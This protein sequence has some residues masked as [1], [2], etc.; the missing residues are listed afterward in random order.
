MAS[1]ATKLLK[2]IEPLAAPA[3]QHAVAVCALRLRGTAELTGLLAE[4]AAGGHYERLLAGRMA[5]VANESDFL[6]RQ[7]DSP[8]PELAAR[9]V[10][11]LVRARIEPDALLDRLPRMSHR[12]RRAL[13]RALGR[14]GRG[15]TADPLLPVIR[16]HFGDAE[17]ARILA[18]CTESTVAEYLPELDYAV[19][20]WAA[21]GHRHLDVVLAYAEEKADI[22]GESDWWELWPRVGA[23]ARAAAEHQPD[24]LLALARR[25]V[26]FTSV[27]QLRPVAGQLAR[28]DPA[29][30][31]ALVLHSSGRGAELTGQALWVA[32]RELPDER[33]IA[34]G[35]VYPHYHRTRFLRALAPARR[36]VVVRAVWARPGIDPGDID[37]TLLDLLPRPARAELARELLARPGGSEVRAVRERLTARL[38]WPDAEPVLAQAI[39]RP[40]ADER[41]TAYPL[42]IA[43]AFGARDPEVLGDLLDTLRRLRNE[44]DPVRAQAFQA[45]TAMPPTLL[46]PDHLPAL[47]QICADALEARDRSYSTTAAVATLA[48]LL[49]LRAATSTT[50]AAAATTSAATSTTSAATSMAGTTTTTGAAARTTGGFAATALRLLELLAAQTTRVPLGRIH[51]NLPRGAE[52]H[53]FEALRPRLD[54]DGARDEWELALDLAAGLDKRA[55]NL[56]DLHRMVL[57]A[58]GARSDSTVRRAVDLALAD[59]ATRDDALNALVKRD[60]SLITLPP[61][62]RLIGLRRTDLLDSLLGAATPGRF[63]SAKVRFVP[64][65]PGGFGSWTPAQVEQYARLLSA[66][67]DHRKSSLWESRWAVRQLGRLPGGFDRL[68]GYTADQRLSVAEAALTALGE[69]ADPERALGLLAGQV[70]SD[71]ARVAVS[72]MAT[73]AKGIAPDRLTSTTAALLA[74]PKITAKKEGVR[75]LAE[76]HAPE[77][78]DVIGEVWRTPGQHRDVRRAAV[79]ACRFLLD[80]DAAW[81]VLSQA[82]A[83]PEVASELSGYAPRLLPIQQ[84]RRMAGLLLG[85]AHNTDEQLAS[86]AISLLPLW[87]RW[88]PPEAGAQLARRICDLSELGVW[89]GAVAALVAHTTTTGDVTALAEAVRQLLAAEDIELPGRD[90]PARQRLS[91]LVT[92]VQAVARRS[93]AGRTAAMSIAVTLGTAPLWRQAAIDLHLAGI[94]WHAPESAIEAIRRAAELAD[95]LLI[96][97]PARHLEQALSTAT[98]RASNPATMWTIANELSSHVDLPTAYAA[99]TLITLCGNHFGWTEPWVELL[100][101]MRAHDKIDIRAAA[102]AEFTIAE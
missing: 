28:H 68:A 44:Q 76:L 14:T 9:A 4:L 33:L 18:Y 55:R 70:D 13:Y 53:L 92:Q 59:P 42:L 71:R 7:L 90:L 102:S 48:R 30:V 47:E 60:R 16:R 10:H 22:A 45:L 56:P 86:Q 39:R 19:P 62:Q 36:A 63:L 94:R 75:L 65:F 73:C 82:A 84:R 32:L 85:L 1:T 3:R 23:C 35:S 98:L 96:C 93:A 8:A 95:G 69:C 99:V 6:L 58:C 54:N 80:R 66:H 31:Q 50:G 87:S 34:L 97:R 81:A 89:R 77:A 15:Y 72:S 49:L 26:E 100:R 83:D 79:F 17:A 61:V 64:S 46:R 11:A 38:F 37:A 41:A 78:M 24:R 29:A 67:A 91:A 12:T 101:R 43:A 40:T 88:S 2:E 25:A 5:T 57:R 27:Q 51:E 52:R 21:L 20:D 74:S